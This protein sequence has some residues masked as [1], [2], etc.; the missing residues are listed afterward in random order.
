METTVS[1][2]VCLTFD[3]DAI[4]VWIGSMGSKSPSNI[5]RGEFGLVGAKRLLEVL[6]GEDIPATWFIPGHTIETF[7]DACR[8]VVDGGH[9]VGHHN[10]LHE[11]PRTLDED[12]ERA[13]LERGIACVERLTGHRP[14]GFR[15]PAWDHSPTTL[16]LLVELGFAYDS[17]LMAQD[18]EPYYARVGDEIRQDGPLVFGEPLDLI[19][20]PIDWSL[21]DWPYFGLNWNA[22]H[23]GL[24]TPDEVFAVW[25]AEFDYLYERVGNGVF[26]LTMH[27]QIM[28]RGHRLLMLERLIEHM[29]RPGVGFR[30]VGDVAHEWRASHPFDQ[31]G[32]G[33][34]L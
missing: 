19:E 11:N 25:A 8:A 18:F 9:E 17:S 14:R 21:D 15:S 10:Y 5:S 29:R 16:R 3:F 34:N 32:Q 12:S 27:P 2:S 23:V 1:V 24:R 30:R 6:A 26:N 22:H 13:V 31:Q 4:S 28:G 7:P 20:M 33:G